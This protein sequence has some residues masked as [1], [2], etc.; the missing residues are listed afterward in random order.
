[1]LSI[2]IITMMYMQWLHNCITASLIGWVEYPLN[3]HWIP[4]WHVELV[5]HRLHAYSRNTHKSILSYSVYP[6]SHKSILLCSVYPYT[7][8]PI[9][10]YSYTHKSILLILPYTRILLIPVLPSS[11]PNTPYCLYTLKY[12]T[13]SQYFLYSQVHTH[14]ISYTPILSFID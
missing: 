1:M 8:E 10:L 7:L 2:R 14:N 5:T 4:P 6:Y 12:C 11:H 13:Y 9:L 3:T